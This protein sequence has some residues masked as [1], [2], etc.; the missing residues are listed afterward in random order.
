LQKPVPLH[1]GGGGEVGQL[2]KPGSMTRFANDGL[3]E[4]ISRQAAKAEIRQQ[5]MSSSRPLDRTQFN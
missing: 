1:P 3:I 5:A 4:A 2:S